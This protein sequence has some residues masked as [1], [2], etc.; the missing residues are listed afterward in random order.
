M[1]ASVSANDHECSVLGNRFEYDGRPVLNLNHLQRRIKAQVDHKV[2]QGIYQFEFEACCICGAMDTDTLASKDR[3]GLYMPVVLCRECGL[4]YTN[5]RM[6]QEAYARFYNDEYRKLYGGTVIPTEQFFEEQ[7]DQGRLIFDYLAR[8]HA[9]PKAPE[10]MSVLEVG[11]GAGGILKYFQEQGYQV[12]GIDLG[13]TYVRFGRDRYRLDLL[14]GTLADLADDEAPDLILYS[15]A[16]EHILEPNR[17]LDMI[18]SRLAPRGLLYLE[19][20]GVKNLMNSYRLDFLRLLQNAHT[21]HFT[22]TTLKNLLHKNGF[23]L[24]VGDETI[25]SVFRPSAAPPR[26]VPLTNDHADVLAYLHRAERWRKILPFPPYVLK[27]PRLVL[28]RILKRLRL[29]GAKI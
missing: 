22:L 10:A 6:N 5:P 9:L 29:L 19:V 7:Y 14:T 3:Y 12:R 20:P 27:Q 18:R 17:E 28:P 13:E 2:D 26:D 15:H 23:E 24:V 25:R 8:H 21:Y 4:I 16:L 11:C 1:I